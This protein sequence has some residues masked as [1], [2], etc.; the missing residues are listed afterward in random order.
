MR[1]R[2]VL[3]SVGSLFLAL[4]ACS[5]SDVPAPTEIASGSLN[6]P[7]LPSSTSA[8]LP[9]STVADVIT[10]PPPPLAESSPGDSIV[11]KAQSGDTLRVVAVHFAVVPSDISSAGSPLPAETEM[12]VPGQI[13]GV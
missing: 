2:F 5:R 3:L 8:P 11:Y 12:L 1:L 4:L 7:V 13:L 6:P 10:P 9:T